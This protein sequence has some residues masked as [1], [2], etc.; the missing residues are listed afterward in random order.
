MIILDTLNRAVFHG[1][2]CVPSFICKVQ[3]FWLIGWIPFV[4]MKIVMTLPFNTF[5]STVIVLLCCSCL[6]THNSDMFRQSVSSTNS[7][8]WVLKWDKS[9]GAAGVLHWE[10]A[11]TTHWI[12]APHAASANNGSQGTWDWWH[13]TCPAPPDGDGGTLQGQYRVK[14]TLQIIWS[15]SSPSP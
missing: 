2:G 4:G 5:G 13:K 3:S 15:P 6:P 10:Q 14:N 12:S 8:L 7:K 11:E 1:C 9:G